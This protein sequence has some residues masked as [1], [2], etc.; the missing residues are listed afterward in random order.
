MW[1]KGVEKC[2]RNWGNVCLAIFFWMIFGSF[3]IDLD[4]VT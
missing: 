1:L 3:D 2:G 4:D